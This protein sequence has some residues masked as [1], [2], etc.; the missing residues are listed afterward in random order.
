MD[1]K[2]TIAIILKDLEDARNILDDLKKYQ[3][4][5]AFQIEL[6]KAK[7]RSAED[8]IR[9]L[10]DMD[11]EQVDTS[12]PVK[13]IEEPAEPELISSEPEEALHEAAPN[14]SLIEDEDIE[15]KDITETILD[16]I[17]EA[18]VAK[19]QS[20]DL[21]DYKNQILAD[22]FKKNSS[23]N[24][25]IAHKRHDEEN[26]E[27]SKLKPLKNLTEAIGINEKFMFIRELFNGNPDLYKQ[28]LDE[29]NN[30][31]NID[32]AFTLLSK[33]APGSSGTEAFDKLLDLVK[34]K[35]ANS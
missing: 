14:L 16:E 30:T 25:Q 13:K 8:V 31:V 35:L 21:R 15:E 10:G 26:S 29:L 5:P 4:V 9:I 6:A 32:S 27:I 23:I 7:C 1:L 24:E 12:K 18:P 3:D 19:S 28:T 33:S 2:S 34:R 20:E 11:F 17:V 22:T